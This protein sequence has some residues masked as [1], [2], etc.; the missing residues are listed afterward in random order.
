MQAVAER[1]KGT[2]NEI[3]LDGGLSGFDQ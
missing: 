2:D 3:E 1:L